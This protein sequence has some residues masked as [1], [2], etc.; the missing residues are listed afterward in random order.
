MLY[1]DYN[2]TSPLCDA[3]R[4]AWIEAQDRYFANPSSLHRSGQRAEHALETARDQLAQLLHCSASELIW[5]SGATEAA[6]A[7]LASL[8][9]STPGALLV[10]PLEHPCILECARR[11]FAGRH[12]FLKCDDSGRVD[13]AEVQSALALGGISTVALMAANNETG[14]LQ[15][16]RDVA[17]LCK[18]RDVPF[19]C[20]A[21]QWVGRMPLDGLH[22]CSYVF[23]STHKAGGP[24][25]VGF[26]KTPPAGPRPPY[27]SPAW[28]PL[29][30]GGPQEDARRAGTQDVAG[31]L[32][33]TA[34]LLDRQPRIAEVASQTLL[35]EQTERALKDSVP[36]LEIVASSSARLWNT[37]SLLLPELPDCRRRWVVRL[38]SA[39]I[40]ASSGSAC[41]S[42]RESPSH[43]LRA[44]GLEACADRVVRLSGGWET[45]AADW[46]RA[47]EI[48]RHVAEKELGRTPASQTD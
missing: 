6:N 26:I 45:S 13:P 41:A 1:L 5:T 32:A 25:G 24:V 31:V 29:L 33:L 44:M 11:W 46:E 42:G 15:P 37:I 16:W 23:A 38:D 27:G 22:E 8:A 47:V 18:E 3:A 48:L 30:V 12:H 40:A 36:G 35:R 39:G 4:R 7:V 19:V 28:T 20:D 43:V 14:V 34:T 2:A 9:A 21:T 17:A 10:S